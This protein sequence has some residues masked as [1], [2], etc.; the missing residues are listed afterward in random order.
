V[1]KLVKQSIEA[2]ANAI[3][4]SSLCII[5]SFKLQ[6]PRKI[7]IEVNFVETCGPIILLNQVAPLHVGV[8]ANLVDDLIA[9][10]VKFMQGAPPQQCFNCVLGGRVQLD[11]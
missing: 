2:I 4:E 10:P 7:I 6:R 3:A 8:G 5:A 11:W 1:A 9:V